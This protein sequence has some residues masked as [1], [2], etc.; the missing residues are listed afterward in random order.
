M[1][2]MRLFKS[3]AEIT[4]MRRAGQFSGRAITNAMQSTF[5][6]EKSLD[7]FLEW[8][9]KVQ[10]CDTSAYIPVVAGGTVRKCVSS[11]SGL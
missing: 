10:G 6:T 9:F 7:A 5:D 2:S 4:V 11:S 3:D 8:Q 1:N